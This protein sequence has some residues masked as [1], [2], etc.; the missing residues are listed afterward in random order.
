M[1]KLSALLKYYRESSDLSQQQV[2]QALNI[3][4]ST[5]TY[6]ETA[7]TLPNAKTIIKLARILN[8]PYQEFFDCVGEELY[9]EEQSTKVADS[10]DT[11]NTFKHKSTLKSKI[12]ELSD[13]EKELILHFRSLSIKGQNDFLNDV[14][15]YDTKDIPAFPHTDDNS[16]KK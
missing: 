11:V 4:R 16:F 15:K 13:D 3:D 10:D 12:Y 9:S 5:Y 1:S 14:F 8:V 2:A 6:Y 7:K